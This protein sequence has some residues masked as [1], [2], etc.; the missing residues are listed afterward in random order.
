MEIGLALP[1]LDRWQRVADVARRAEALGVASLWL[2]D[3]HPAGGGRAAQA[4]DGI[5]PL[6]ALAGLAEVTS[7]PRLGVLLR[8]GMRPPAVVAKA[9]STADILSGGRVILGLS[10]GPDAE[11]GEADRLGEAM[12]VV[13]GAFEGGPF[14]FEG[15]HHRV[16]ALRC[17]P[18][19]LQSPGPQ[20]WIS[21]SG[22]PLLAT[23][24]RHGD[25]W[26]PSGSTGTIA[27]Y[28]R[29][30]AALDQACEK[31]GRDPGGVTRFV[32]RELPVGTPAEVAEQV[33]AWEECGVATLILDGGALALPVANGDQLEDQLLYQLEMVASAV[34]SAN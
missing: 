23:V 30:A 2:A 25:G 21:G 10:E 11:A 28:R 22:G 4:Y 13:K 20:V 9:L 5:E 1:R 34:S 32:S 8:T 27:D 17:R 24:A 14:T 18:R 12:Q 19:P 26:G 7:G 3:P 33:V 6:T 31:A 15:R 16:N 29:L